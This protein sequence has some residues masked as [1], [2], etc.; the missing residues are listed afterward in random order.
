[1][2]KYQYAMKPNGE[3][4]Q[5]EMSKKDIM[6]EP[7]KYKLKS[8]REVMLTRAQKEFSKLKRLNV[9]DKDTFEKDSFEWN[10][11]DAKEMLDALPGKDSPEV[12]IERFGKL[13]LYKLNVLICL[14]LHIL[15][16]RNGPQNYARLA[17]ISVSNNNPIDFKQQSVPVFKISAIWLRAG[18]TWSENSSG[19]QNLFG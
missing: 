1:M 6:S 13:K 17:R 15:H 16:V 12:A 5:D 14:K 7:N 11:L 4:I 18:S 19:C 2:D 8:F 10:M 3:H 9:Q